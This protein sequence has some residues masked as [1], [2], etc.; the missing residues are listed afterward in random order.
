MESRGQSHIETGYLH[1][2]YGAVHGTSDRQRP[3]GIAAN[4]LLRHTSG[5][6]HDVL[7]AQIRL[8]SEEN[9]A[10]IAAV[11]N[12]QVHAKLGFDVGVGR[13]ETERRQV[14]R[15]GVEPQ[16]G[17]EVLYGYAA[18]LLEGAVAHLQLRE[19]SFVLHGIEG[20]A[21]VGQRDVVVVKS[22]YTRRKV[23]V[24]GQT[25]SV[26]LQCAHSIQ[27]FI[28]VNLRIG[29]GQLVHAGTYAERV[30]GHVDCNGSVLHLKPRHVN[31]PLGLCS[32]RILRY[33]VTKSH[34]H[35]SVRQ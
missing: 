3:V 4:E 24:V 32:G 27:F 18:L 31:L 15:R 23:V 25:T 26:P 13:A 5:E 30:A 21:D 1:A 14:Y 34:I 8:Q 6:E 7:F 12:V 10:R 33:G 35:L 28:Q 19:R 29:H 17:A 9:L 11:H 22:S 16:T 20:N 2:L